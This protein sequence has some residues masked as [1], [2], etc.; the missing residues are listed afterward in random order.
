[1][2]INPYFLDALSKYIVDGKKDNCDMDFTIL[3]GAIQ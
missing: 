3:H 2:V 1:M